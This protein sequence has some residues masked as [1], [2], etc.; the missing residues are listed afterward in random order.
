MLLHTQCVC[1]RCSDIQVDEDQEDEDG[2]WDRDSDMDD[3]DDWY[4]LSFARTFYFVFSTAANML[5]LFPYTVSMC[6]EE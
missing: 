2:R 1:S 5:G 3:V 6:Q 4:I